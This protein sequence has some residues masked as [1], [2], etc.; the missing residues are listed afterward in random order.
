[1]GLVAIYPNSTMV[2]ARFLGVEGHINA[3]IL[4]GFVVVYLIVFKLL[5]EV[6]RIEKN[7]HEITQ[8]EGV[9]KRTLQCSKKQHDREE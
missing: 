9:G 1:M 3:I 2:V 6:E 5:S 4:T 7:L 8:R